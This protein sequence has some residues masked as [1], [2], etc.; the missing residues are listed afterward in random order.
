M[1]DAPHSKL[2]FFD[3]GSET[4]SEKRRDLPQVADAFAGSLAPRFKRISSLECGAVIHFPKWKNFR[5]I[6]PRNVSTE[7]GEAQTRATL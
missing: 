5:A 3:L 6:G 2:K 7:G 4:S 1:Y